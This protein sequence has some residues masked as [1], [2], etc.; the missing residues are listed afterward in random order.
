[1]VSGEA[2]KTNFLVFGLTRSGLESMIYRTR[3]EHPNHYTTDAFHS[4]QVVWTLRQCDYQILNSKCWYNFRILAHSVVGHMNYWL[5]LSAC[6]LFHIS[7]FFC[8]IA[9]SILR[10]WPMLRV[11]LDFLQMNLMLHGEGA[12][13]GLKIENLV[14][15][16]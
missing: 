15:L 12:I 6:K 11:H 4:C 1:M 5:P 9:G 7:I 2:T 8:K 3:G 13:M 14:N 10:E 16:N